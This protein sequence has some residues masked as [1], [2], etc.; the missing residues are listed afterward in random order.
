MARGYGAGPS[1]TGSRGRGPGGRS[2]P[3]RGGGGP[4][5]STKMCPTCKGSGRVSAG[6]KP[7]PTKMISTKSKNRTK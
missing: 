3:S 5:T 6:K 4:T 2:A 7:S 1:G